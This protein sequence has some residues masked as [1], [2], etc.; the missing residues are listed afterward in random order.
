VSCD[1]RADDQ[2]YREWLARVAEPSARLAPVRAIGSEASRLRVGRLIGRMPGMPEGEQVAAV[3][4]LSVEDRRTYMG[5]VKLA[6]GELYGSPEREPQRPTVRRSR[7]ARRPPD[8]SRWAAFVG[9]F[10]RGVALALFLL[11]LAFVMLA[12]SSPSQPAHAPAY[13]QQQERRTE[14]REALGYQEEQEQAEYA[15]SPGPPY[16]TKGWR[17]SDP[18]GT[19]R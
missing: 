7:P 2:S 4:A 9:G 18:T 19:E 3:E 14:E 15:N 5:A 12:H 11:V 6:A 13:V 17:A 8:R 10:R 1:V 16:P